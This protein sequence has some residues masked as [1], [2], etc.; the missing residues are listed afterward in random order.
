MSFQFLH[1]ILVSL[2]IPIVLID[3]IDQYTV[4]RGTLPTKEHIW[5]T[6]SILD[7][8]H[9]TTTQNTSRKRKRWWR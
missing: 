4:S 8:Y 5:C 9:K 3:L 2:N 1:N 6:T 7:S